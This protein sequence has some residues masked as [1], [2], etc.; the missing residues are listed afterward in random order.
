MDTTLT[1]HLDKKDKERIFKFARD[2]RL[3]V[4]SWVRLQMIQILRANKEENSQDE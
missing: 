3:S 2:S 1:F 4:S